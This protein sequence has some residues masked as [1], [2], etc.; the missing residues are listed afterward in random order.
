MKDKICPDTYKSDAALK[1]AV[2]HQQ[3]GDHLV[4]NFCDHA[5]FLSA[6]KMT[7]F[8]DTSPPPDMLSD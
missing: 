7:Q 4:G 6:N 3:V 5:H 8:D 1:E 2:I